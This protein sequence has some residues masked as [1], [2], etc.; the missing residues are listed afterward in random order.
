MYVHDVAIAL[1]KRG[2][3]PIVYS[4][5]LGDVADQIRI[6]TIPVVDNLNAVAVPPDIIHGHHHLETLTALLHFPNTPAIYFCHGWSPWEETPLQFPR[7]QRYVAV[8][9][10]SY[11]RLVYE[12]GINPDKVHYLLN[13][14][15]L[16]RFKP[17]PTPLPSK[18]Q[19]AL[20]YNNSSSQLE[21]LSVIKDACRE[22]DIQ[23]DIVGYYHGSP[24]AHPEF[25]LSQYDLVFAKARSA[26]EAMAMGT[27]VILCNASNMGPMVGTDNFSAL[28]PLN[29]GIRALNEQLNKEALIREIHRYNAQ[30][31]T[32]IS[33]RIRADAD[34]QL[35]I[36]NLVDLYQTSIAEYSCT[37]PQKNDFSL[38]RNAIARYLLFLK[39][40]L[41]NYRK[42]FFEWQQ[43]NHQ[44]QQFSIESK[45]IREEN[46]E[47][48]EKYSVLCRENNELINNSQREKEQNNK[49]Q[50]ALLAIQQCKTLRLKKRL[51]QLPF[52]GKIVTLLSNLLK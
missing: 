1:H 51:Y 24:A 6:A 45:Y 20:I 33:Q 35:I 29:F 14:A 34:M 32:Q 52:V 40:M 41:H 11:D 22:L 38:E 3:K 50:A 26:I 49:L 9:Q 25:I 28:R 12:G 7:I 10:P 8:C 19:K 17:R 46:L 15:D 16:D 37:L 27:A 5:I 13:F 42:V 48:A 43:A 39:P 2:H 18:P 23:C 4:P 36:N 31:A 30:D 44:C 21:E 47:L